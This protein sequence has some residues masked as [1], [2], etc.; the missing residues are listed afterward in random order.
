MRLYGLTEKGLSVSRNIYNADTPLYRIIAYLYTHNRATIEN[1]ADSCGL[2]PSQASKI[3]RFKLN[4][5][6]AE[7]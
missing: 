1:I 3:I 7:E 2:T 4:G 5:I 6:V